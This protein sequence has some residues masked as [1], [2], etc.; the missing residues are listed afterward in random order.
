MC[1]LTAIKIMGFL[2]SNLTVKGLRGYPKSGSPPLIHL[3]TN[4]FF[5]IL[6]VMKYE[7]VDFGGFPV[8]LR[9]G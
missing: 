9:V 6:I 5:D 7:T 2:I 4:Y 3:V 8:T 1:P